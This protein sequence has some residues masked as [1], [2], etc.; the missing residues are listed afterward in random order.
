MDFKL[1]HNYKILQNHTPS[2]ETN[3]MET[4][5]Y[6]YNLLQQFNH[7]LKVKGK[8]ETIERF[9]SAP[10]KTDLKNASASRLVDIP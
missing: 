8:N 2:K 9:I 7:A 5:S 4:N 1:L 3:S 10:T 6:V